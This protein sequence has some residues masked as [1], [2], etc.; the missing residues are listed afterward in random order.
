MRNFYKLLIVIFSLLT[1]LYSG[2]ASAQKNSKSADQTE[3]GNNEGGDIST[4][5]TA[6][7]KDAIFDSSASY[8]L[9][10]KNASNTTQTGKVSYQITDQFN[11]KLRQDSVLVNISRQS[12]HSYDFTIPALKSGFYKINFM[13]NVTDYDDTTRRVFGIRPEEIRSAHAKPADFDS[14]WESTKAELAKVQPEYKITEEYDLEKDKRRVFLIEMK[15]LG[16]VTIYAWLTEPEHHMKHQTFP[17][18]LML[19]GYQATNIPL[20]GRDDDM[21]FVGLDVRG[22]GLSKKGMEMRREDY[23]VSGLEDKDKY[24]MRGIIMDCIRAVDFIFTRP[25]LSKDRI[26]VT[27]GSMGGYL[28]ITTAALDKRITL[29]GPQNP[30]FSDIYNMDNGAVQWPLDHMR[31]Y[32]KIRPDLTFEKALDNLQYFDTKNFAGSINCPVIMGIGLLDPFVPPNNSYAVYNNIKSKK[33]LFVFKDLGHEVGDKYY[34]YETLFTRDAFGL[35][36]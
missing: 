1:A 24:I 27:G 3:N 11:K 10:V 26:A 14:F 8:T 28:S 5:L 22:Q 23:I 16:N 29:C 7:S 15:S 21:A 34:R 13:I 32:A 31:E 4:V 25:E 30:F 6:H 12:S 9:E 17:V 33:K 18:L 35:F 20:M 19:P 36:F 2:Q